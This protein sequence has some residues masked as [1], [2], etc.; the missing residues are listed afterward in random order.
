M[1]ISIVRVIRLVGFVRCVMIIS[2]VRVI[3]LVGF[4]RVV[5]QQTHLPL[6]SEFSMVFCAFDM[7][8]IGFFSGD[9][10]NGISFIV[11]AEGY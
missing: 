3:R 6:S 10:L 5:S 7:G 1:I 9:C 8:F 11:A 4:V 2:I